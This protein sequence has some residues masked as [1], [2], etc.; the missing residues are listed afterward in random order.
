MKQARKSTPASV[1]FWSRA[2][3][4]PW[5][6]CG[7]YTSWKYNPKEST[8]EGSGSAA[9]RKTHRKDIYRALTSN[10]WFCFQAG[11]RAMTSPIYPRSMD[12][13]FIPTNSFGQDFD[14][15]LLCRFWGG[16][17]FVGSAIIVRKIR[18]LRRKKKSNE[19]I[20]KCACK[21]ILFSLYIYVKSW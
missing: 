5:W 9:D 3:Q 20:K 2:Q 12:Q 1:N 16:E 15:K 18:I 11:K 21:G 17:A 10:F 13:L 14:M 6:S 7:C 8:A 19:T 4:I